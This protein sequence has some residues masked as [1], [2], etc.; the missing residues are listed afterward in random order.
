MNPADQG[1][2]VI[3]KGAGIGPS[4]MRLL[5][6]AEAGEHITPPQG[7]TV[8]NPFISMYAAAMAARANLQNLIAA[9]FYSATGLLPPKSERKTRTRIPGHTHPAGS[10]IAR[11]FLEARGLEWDGQVVHTGALTA[12][13][14]S[15]ALRR[16]QGLTVKG[17]A[18]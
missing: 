5:S 16:A 7:D 3:T 12:A 13:N 17:K 9:K 11:R 14:R 1:V 10:K 6:L 8:S 15:R 4:E 18:R 2:I